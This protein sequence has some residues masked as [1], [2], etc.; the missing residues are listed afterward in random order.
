[1]MITVSEVIKNGTL[2]NF[3]IVCGVSG[4]GNE[5]TKTGIID[6]E[7]AIEGFFENNQPFGYGDFLVAS[8]MFTNGDESILLKMVEKL[9]ELRVSG[10]A[11]KNIFFKTI[12]RSVV[13]LCN[14]KA[15]PIVLF[16]NSLYFE[17]IITEI[18]N[19]IQVSDWVKQIET[20][21]GLLY[22][23]DLT[24]REVEVISKEMRI[25][26]RKHG[27]AFF[28]IPKIS[29]RHLN[30]QHIIN[31]YRNHP[32]H[33]EKISFFKYQQAFVVIV[34]SDSDIKPKF[35]KSFLDMLHLIG[36]QVSDY[37]VGISSIH[38]PVGE[39]DVCIKEAIWSQKVA[40]IMAVERKKFSDIGTWS[41]L[42]CNQ[43]FKHIT[44]Y[45]EHYL[46]SIKNNSSDSSKELIKTAIAYIKCEGNTKLTADSLFIHENTV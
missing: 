3:L 44:Q 5:V 15:F 12:P 40:S 8:L 17:E 41:I 21:I 27:V 7:F 43:Q 11:V 9:I 36:I 25:S 38:D 14:E 4:L 46:K 37:C 10:L 6:Y 18:D 35:E 28:M 39:L 13:D 1:M 24:R 45:M 32:Y 30:M 26:Q 19:I 29:L 16:D 33:D 42:L 20:K 23:K 22:L 31:S 34:A 2:K